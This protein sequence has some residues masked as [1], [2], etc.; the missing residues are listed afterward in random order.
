M[1]EIC[2]GEYCFFFS[3]NFYFDVRRTVFVDDFEGHE[4]AVSLYG[5]VVPSS[6]NQTF[7]VKKRVG[8]V[9]GCLIFC[10]LAY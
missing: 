3:E 8:W 10:G 5:F 6:S 7:D 1:A 2:S 4:F 9:Q